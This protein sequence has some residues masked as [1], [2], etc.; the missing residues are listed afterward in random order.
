MSYVFTNSVSIFNS[1]TNSISNTEPLPITGNVVIFNSNGSAINASSRLPVDIGNNTISISGNVNVTTASN[2]SIHQSNGDNITAAEALPVAINNFPSTSNVLIFNS[3]GSSINNVNPLFTTFSPFTT[4]VI[5]NVFIQTSNQISIYQSNGDSIT[6]AE[7]LPVAINNFPNSVNSLLYFANTIPV[8]NSAPIPVDVISNTTNYVYT[9]QA[10]TWS[11]DALSK[12]RISTTSSQNWF[13]PVVDDDI[14]YRWSQILN[15][16]NSNSIFL[17]N[18][19]EIQMTSGNTAGGYAYKQTYNRYKI[20]PGT[21]H[22]LYT[23]V[24]YEVT[25]GE[26]GVIRRTGLFDINN[27]IYWE[28]GNT[29][30]NT[31]AVV[32]R[33]QVANG[34]IV[35]DRVYANSFNQDKL[36]GTGPSGMNIFTTGLNKYY[37]FWFDLIG[38][39]TGRVRFGLGTPIGPQIVH[40]QSYSSPS[41]IGNT[42]FITDN[43]LPLRREILNGSTGSFT[44]TTPVFNM[45][46]I[47]FQSD[48]ELSSNP[49]PTTAYNV[50]GYIPGTTLTPVLTIGLRAGSPWIG[51]DISPGEF[52]IIDQNNQ[53][54]NATADTFLYTIV[55]NANVN[56]TYAYNGNSALI[57][58]N[59]GRSSRYWTW[60]NTATI[61]GGLTILSGLTASGA[62]STTFDGIPGTYNLGSD[63]N[64][65]PATLTLC[66]QNL[67]GSIGGTANVVCSW[68]F[69]EEL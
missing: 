59:T 43:S 46:G 33:R 42:T 30:A 56:G 66:I 14:L 9:Q 26:S 62:G 40:I 15:G 8:S 54:K 25:A 68:N 55:Y 2:V 65:N 50:S 18:T 19:S 35:E 64:G 17:A 23:T 39:R 1:N 51:S 13:V 48:A 44:T 7:A 61:T 69:I 38:G 16:T 34:S 24:N 58:A 31:L 36:D 60:S 11:T 49:S 20:I 37:T 53:G 12:L 41:L 21:S 10:P 67:P 27:G 3:D 47:A 22:T 28:Q 45:S 32:V 63:I 52:T 57:N 29:S 4:E 5:G 6:A